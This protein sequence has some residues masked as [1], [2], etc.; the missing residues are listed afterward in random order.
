M[1]N[2]RTDDFSPL[3]NA[4]NNEKE[5]YFPIGTYIVS[6]TIKIPS[7]RKLLFERGAVLRLKASSPR[8]RGDFLLTNADEK[9]G[10]EN[11]T[12]IGAT[13]DGNNGYRYHKRPNDIFKKDG[14]SGILINFC[15]VKN[16]TLSKITLQNPVSY[17]TR[18]CKIDG[19]LIEDIVLKSKKI[20]P[21]QD[22]IH[23]AGNVRN[24]YVKNVRADSYGQTNDD[25]LAIN[26]DDYPDRIEEFD[27]ECG[28]IENILF[29]DIHAESC[30]DA[31][32]LI[33][34]RSAIRN[35][36]F[37]N[38]NVGFRRYAID[39]N[40][41]RGCRAEL[42]R[43]EDEPNGVGSV[44]NVKFLDCTFWHTTEYPLFWKGS[45]GDRP[46]PYIIWGSIGKAVEIKNCRFIDPPPLHKIFKK[47]IKN[48]KEDFPYFMINNVVQQ[49]IDSDGKIYNIEKK[50]DKIILSEFNNL[51][52]DVTK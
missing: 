40:A 19:F 18:F 48:G 22:G 12:V 26:A 35:L 21:N 47:K 50:E 41:A 37:K 33:S 20:K 42:F 2:G 30:H 1:G 16:L 11:I 27:T 51:S 52:I 44:E 5:L 8:K 31:V 39:N 45:T 3:Q 10:N 36:T 49:T 15:N 46:H 28:V 23:F 29:E 9:N 17:F 25:L 34:Y 38:L 24:G 4:I 13:F 7:D 14:Y 6:D 32:R 43:E